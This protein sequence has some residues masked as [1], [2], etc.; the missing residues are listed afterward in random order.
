MAI[1]TVI[2]GGLLARRR[3]DLD[4]LQRLAVSLHADRGMNP[5]YPM[6]WQKRIPRRGVAAPVRDE[7]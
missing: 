7:G 4:I 5:E 1:I 6:W 3:R 2:G